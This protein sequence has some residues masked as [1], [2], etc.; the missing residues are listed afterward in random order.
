MA[1]YGEL[2][3]SGKLKEIEKT[4]KDYHKQKKETDAKRKA[5]E[6]VNIV[7]GRGTGRTHKDVVKDTE[8]KANEILGKTTKPEPKPEAYG[9]QP[10]GGVA[11]EQVIAETRP[12]TTEELDAG[13]TQNDIDNGQTLA[14][15]GTVMAVTPGD[16]LSL[17]GIGGLAKRLFGGAVVKAGTKVTAKQAA[18]GFFNVKNPATKKSIARVAKAFGRDLED[19]TAMVEH[20]ALSKEITNIVTKATTG[21]KAMKLIKTGLKIGAGIAGT[22]VLVSWYAMD[23][24]ISGQKFYVKDLADGVR[25]KTIDP[26]E[27]LDAMQDS[28]ETRQTAIDFVSKSATLNPTLWPFKKLIETGLV[29]D[30]RS[31]VLNENELMTNIEKINAEEKNNG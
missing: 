31:I 28:K 16:I 3:R 18:K 27:A 4:A 21:A 10:E 9:P 26:A 29:G 14:S 5:R 30:E 12:I 17:V 6:T 25:Y 22:D 24:I 11:P 19:L 20:R 15:V 8:T 23:N 1:T 7:S 2:K 13:L